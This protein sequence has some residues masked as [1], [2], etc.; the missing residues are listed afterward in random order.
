MT[1]LKADY[2]KIMY[3]CKNSIYFIVKFCALIT[4][5]CQNCKIQFHWKRDLFRWVSVL[6]FKIHWKKYDKMI[7]FQTSFKPKELFDLIFFL[8]H[9]QKAIISRASTRSTC[10]SF[11]TYFSEFSWFSVHK[12]WRTILNLN[13]P[14]QNLTRIWSVVDVMTMN[15]LL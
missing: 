5:L 2:Y 15:L 9:F 14:S 13:T 1:I 10:F 4:V 11:L 6:F 12:M 3:C 7:P 8:K